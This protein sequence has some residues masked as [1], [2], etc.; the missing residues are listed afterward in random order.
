MD[1]KTCSENDKDLNLFNI[2]H[3]FIEFCKTIVFLDDGNS[4]TVTCQVHRKV[5]LDVE[6]KHRSSDVNKST[7][8]VVDVG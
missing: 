1:S 8:H 4:F 2:I 3:S 6:I 5:R 7:D